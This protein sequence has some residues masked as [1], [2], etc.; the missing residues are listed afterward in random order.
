M[1]AWRMITVIS[2]KTHENSKCFPQKNNNNNYTAKDDSKG[3]N[4]FL[5]L[6]QFKDERDQRKS[7]RGMML[8]KITTK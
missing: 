1:P 5:L 3:E 8:L 7:K 2:L 4:T 6:E